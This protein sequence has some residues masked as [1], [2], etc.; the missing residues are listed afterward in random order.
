MLFDG[1]GIRVVCSNK[2][3]AGVMGSS[4]CATK[5]P[6]VEELRYV[7]SVEAEYPHAGMAWKL[8]EPVLDFVEPPVWA[9]YRP[10]L[11]AVVEERPFAKHEYELKFIKSL[12][13]L[14]ELN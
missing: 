14:P 11:F 2:L 1:C 5:D 3:V 7:K 9:I 8:G 13:G 4:S 12:L 6:R 10:E